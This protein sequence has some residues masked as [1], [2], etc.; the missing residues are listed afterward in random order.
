VVLG[1]VQAHGGGIT[2]ESRSGQGSVFRLFFPVAEP[3]L[4]T[5]PDTTQ[6]GKINKKSE[7]EKSGVILVADDEDMV[8]RVIEAMLR[9]I[10]FDVLTARDGIEAV[11]TFRKNKE[12][13]VLVISDLSMPRMNGWETL[14]ALRKLE[15]NIPVILA[16]GYDE[17]H[18][19]KDEYLER[20]Q[21]FLKKPYTRGG[22]EEALAGILSDDKK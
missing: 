5:R 18:V 22:L 13:I 14:T 12:R 21:A 19:M 16:S 15:P 9:K 6:T 4:P 8:R 17:A 7:S 20:P 10:G 3:S 1:I 11:E 2:V